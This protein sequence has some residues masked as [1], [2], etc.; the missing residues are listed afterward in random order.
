MTVLYLRSK[1][2]PYPPPLRPPRTDFVSLDKTRHSSAEVLLSGT[3]RGWGRYRGTPNFRSTKHVLF[4]PAPFSLDKIS[5]S[6]V[7]RAFGITHVMVSAL[8]SFQTTHQKVRL[9][10]IKMAPSYFPRASRSFNASNSELPLACMACRLPR[11]HCLPGLPG[12][13]GMPG[14]PGLA[15]LHQDVHLAQTELY[16]MDFLDGIACAILIKWPTLW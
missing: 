8:R 14:L 16:Q 15:C 11:L 6:S 5:S 2:P 9:A 10:Q 7:R 13:P 3:L 12:L 1:T 4:A